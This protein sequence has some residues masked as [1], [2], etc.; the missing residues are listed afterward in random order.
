M[1][2]T[3]IYRINETDRTIEIAQSVPNDND[4]DKGKD[5]DKEN[6]KTKDDI[7]IEENAEDDNSIHAAVLNTRTFTFDELMNQH[8]IFREHTEPYSSFMDRLQS[9]LRIGRS[10]DVSTE[11]MILLFEAK[12]NENIFFK[13]FVTAIIDFYD[14]ERYELLKPNDVIELTP[15]KKRKK[16]KTKA[17]NIDRFFSERL[18]LLCS[19]AYFNHTAVI[20]HFEMIPGRTVFA[21]DEY[22]Y[23]VFRESDNSLLSLLAEMGQIVHRNKWTIRECGFCHKL[24][25]GTEDDVCCHSEDCIE[26]QKQQKEAIY[27]EHT[28]EYSHIKKTYDAFVRRHDGYLKVVNI[29]KLY[30]EKY[31]EFYQMK[32]SKKKEM[33]ALKKRL[34]NNGLPAQELYDLGEKFKVEIRALAEKLLDECGYDVTEVAKI[35]KRVI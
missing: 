17:E 21:A 19:E 34:I 6:G 12:H 18:K 16:Q 20:E 30:P 33:T 22:T 7:K 14:A 28:E 13:G 2:T 29:H 11:D 35:K 1:K 27:K 15:P 26:A 5:K 4:K 8:K 10:I 9:A 23:N 24:F 25:L 32:E 3:T 31:D